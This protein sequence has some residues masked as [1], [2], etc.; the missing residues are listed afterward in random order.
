MQMWGI[1]LMKYLQTQNIMGAP[2][3]VTV[4]TFMVNIAANKIFIS[5]L[6]FSVGHKADHSGI[7]CPTTCIKRRALYIHTLQQV[8]R[9][10][11]HCGANHWALSVLYR[12][13]STWV[14]TQFYCAKLS[15]LLG[16]Y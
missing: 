4:I 14:Q 6:G 7:F 8:A 11:A 5:V 10:L 1:I 16:I 9:T 12:Q 3:I 13:Q 15:R 2:A